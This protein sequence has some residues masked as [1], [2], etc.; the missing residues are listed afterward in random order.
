MAEGVQLD[1][2]SVGGNRHPSSADWSSALGGY[3]AY[4]AGN[5]VAL[6]SPVVS[7]QNPDIVVYYS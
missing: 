7:Q 1:Y 5:S 2:I 4:S 3:I 6:W